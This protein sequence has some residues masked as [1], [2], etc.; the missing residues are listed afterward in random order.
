MS[1]DRLQM[2]TRPD[3]YPTRLAERAWLDAEGPV[4]WGQSGRPRRR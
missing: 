1:N 4:F 3:V 2:R